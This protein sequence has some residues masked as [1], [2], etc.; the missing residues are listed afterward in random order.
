[1]Q[2]A[3]VRRLIYL[4]SI[5]STKLYSI[6]FAQLWVMVEILAP[7]YHAIRFKRKSRTFEIY[8]LSLQPYLFSLLDISSYNLA[9]TQIIWQVL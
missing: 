8:F 7:R 3:I 5:T 1:M 6:H 2:F 4:T 9:L